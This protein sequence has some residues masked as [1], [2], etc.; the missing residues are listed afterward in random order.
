MKKTIANLAS[1]LAIAM[2]VAGITLVLYAWNLPPFRSAVQVTDNAYV[3]GS[4]TLISPQLSGY[5]VEVPVRD[6]EGVKAGQL[7]ARL[8]DRIFRQKVDQAKAALA[9]QEA[10]LA[11]SIQQ[12]RSAEAKIGASEAAVDSATFALRRATENWTRVEA[13]AKKGVMAESE[14]EQGRTTLDQA[15]AAVTQAKAQLE[16]SKQDLQAIIVGRDSLKAA[17]A[18]AKAA[19]EL[20]EIDLANTRITAPRDGVVGEVGV[21]LGQYVAAGSQLMAV[22]PQGTWIIANFKETQLSRIHSGQPVTFTVDALDDIELHGHV[23]RF[24]PAAGS[25]FSI[26][27]PDNATGNFTK[28]AQRVPVRISIDEGQEQ[29]KYLTPGLSVVVRTVVQDGTATAAAGAVEQPKG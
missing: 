21:K 23:E 22:V 26:I 16:V 8:D 15:E 10:A 3:R 7:L 20:A 9:S 4:V 19:F 28:V 12:Q 14:R 24:S 18:G 1:F 13:L 2:G 27:K 25:E 17:V 5:V 11:N 6:Y 29:A